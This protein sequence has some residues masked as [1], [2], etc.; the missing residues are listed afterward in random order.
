MARDL[1]L[2]NPP[3]PTEELMNCF[4]QTESNQPLSRSNPTTKWVS[5]TIEPREG[6]GWLDRKMVERGSV[7]ER[8]S[9]LLF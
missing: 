3:D 2:M 6:A 5:T 9:S 4:E 7:K 8:I 1:T